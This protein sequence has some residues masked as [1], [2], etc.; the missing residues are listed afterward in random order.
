MQLRKLALILAAGGLIA[1]FFAF[2]LGRYLN[3]QT[4]KEQQAV[5]AA[6]YAE[7][8]LLTV[9]IYFVVYVISTA[10]SLPGATLLTLAGGWRCIFSGHPSILI[11]MNSIAALI[12][13]ICG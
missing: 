12:C 2:D 5:I 11:L 8:P 4:L 1:A 13:T 7:K 3:L 10:L 9:A 6:F